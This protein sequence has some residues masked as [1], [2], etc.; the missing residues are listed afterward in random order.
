M[1][2]QYLVLIFLIGFMLKFSAIIAISPVNDLYK[3]LI[4]IGSFF[5]VI[6]LIV[7]FTREKKKNTIK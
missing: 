4:Y 2:K 1:K 3:I 5:D 7:L 6:G